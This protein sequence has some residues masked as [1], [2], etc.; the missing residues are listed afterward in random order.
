[1][2]TSEP[3]VVGHSSPHPF[4]DEFQVN[5]CVMTFEPEGKKLRARRE[6]K[7]STQFSARNRKNRVN[8]GLLPRRGPG[9]VAD[10]SHKTL[11]QRAD[12]SSMTAENSLKIT[13][14]KQRTK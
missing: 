6:E 8:I 10:D 11:T 4:F 1:M 14:T 5:P 9:G 7:R 3:Q 2:V 13:A 12:Y